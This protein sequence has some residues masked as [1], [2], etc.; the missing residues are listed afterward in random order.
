MQSEI[1]L[2]AQ[3]HGVSIRNVVQLGAI[4]FFR[5]NALSVGFFVFLQT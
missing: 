1:R 2:F 5:V 3:R 4:G